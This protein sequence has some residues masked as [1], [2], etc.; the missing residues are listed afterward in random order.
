MRQQCWK[1]GLWHEGSTLPVVH[2]GAKGVLLCR[3]WFTR[4]MAPFS[5]SSQLC[6]SRHG[7]ACVHLYMT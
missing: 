5:S 1:E 3:E 4:R 2:R 6:A 7:L